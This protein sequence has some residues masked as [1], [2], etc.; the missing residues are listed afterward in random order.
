MSSPANNHAGVAELVS[1]HAYAADFGTVLE[2][3]TAR[4][5]QLFAEAAPVALVCPQCGEPIWD[6]PYASKLAKCWGCGLAFDTMSDDEEAAPW[7]RARDAWHG[8]E[9]ARVD[10]ALGR[11]AVAP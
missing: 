9:A 1:A 7:E 5:D 3:C 2:W 4:T 8:W 6:M 11:Q 10:R